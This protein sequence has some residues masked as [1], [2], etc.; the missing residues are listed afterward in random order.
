MRSRLRTFARAG[1]VAGGLGLAMIAATGVSHAYA[2]DGGDPSSAGCAGRATTVESAT[3]ENAHSAFGTIELRYSAACHTVWARLTL[4][5][6]QPACGNASAGYA[7][8]GA[9][10]IRDDDGRRYGCTIHQGQSQCYTPMVYDKGMTSFAEGAVDRAA[11][12]ADV[13][14][15]AY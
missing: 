8:A 4:D 14:T 3:V 2:H 13:R 7:C 15:A 10:V 5:H 11:G 1:V 12:M 6:T 9:S